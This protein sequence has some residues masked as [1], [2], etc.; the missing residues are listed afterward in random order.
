VFLQQ[1][2]MTQTAYVGNLVCLAVGTSRYSATVCI[3]SGC[4]K[5]CA[6]LD[7]QRAAWSPRMCVCAGVLQDAGIRAPPPLSDPPADPTLTTE[8]AMPPPSQPLADD[9]SER[10]EGPSPKQALQTKTSEVGHC[11]HGRIPQ[12][13]LSCIQ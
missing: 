6:W 11:T 10:I 7:L 3:A 2:G 8:L 5:E 1:T 12:R 4:F 13:V 9:S